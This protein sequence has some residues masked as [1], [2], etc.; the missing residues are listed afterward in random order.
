M[1]SAPAPGVPD[2]TCHDARLHLAVLRRAHELLRR[3]EG[4]GGHGP[5]WGQSTPPSWRGFR[6]TRWLGGAWA[7][8]RLALRWGGRIGR[9]AP[10]PG[11]RV[12]GHQV[13]GGVIDGGGGVEAVRR[14][15]GH[16]ADL[17]SGSFP[18]PSRSAFRCAPRG[19]QFPRGRSTG[20]GRRAP[21]AWFRRRRWRAEPGRA[22]PPILW[23]SSSPRP[24][25]RRARR[26]AQR[27]SA[28]RRSRAHQDSPSEA[29]F[30]VP[31]TAVDPRA[32]RHVRLWPL[33]RVSPLFCPLCGGIDSCS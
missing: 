20:S 21:T 17:G 27:A 12:Q 3:G 9:D 33:L 11:F 7:A 4:Q 22:G 15:K 14:R 23:P 24:G 8:G 16:D 28:S 1:R 18:P 25:C 29:R 32:R 13:Q 31:S 6:R 19:G 30:P 26:V 5:E 2:L 10:A